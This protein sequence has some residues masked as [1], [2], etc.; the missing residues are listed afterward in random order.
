MNDSSKMLDRTTLK[1]VE[2]YCDEEAHENK[3]TLKQI[4]FEV[5]I[6]VTRK[7]L[8]GGLHYVR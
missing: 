4:A 2:N 6:Y 7:D 3:V 5:A 8:R 1:P